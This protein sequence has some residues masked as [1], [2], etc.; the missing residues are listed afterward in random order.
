MRALLITHRPQESAPVRHRR[1]ASFLQP[2]GRFVMHYVEMCMVMCLGAITLSVL[3]FGAAAL[4]GYSDLPQR[5]PALTVLIIAINLSLP[6]AI[7]MRFRGMAW[8]PTLEMSGSTMV[9][10]LLLIAGYRRGI[11][12]QDSLMELQT[13]IL[14]CPLMLA[15]MLVRFPLY[16]TSHQRRHAHPAT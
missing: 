7:W 2:V 6:M 9:A 15:V 10:G 16:S 1:V 11:I 13:G 12:A 14:A 5:A 4:L 3:F 8:R